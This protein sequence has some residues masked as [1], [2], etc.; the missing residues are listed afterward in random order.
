MKFYKNKD[1]IHSVLSEVIPQSTYDKAT[2]VYKKSF[3]LP[4]METVKEEV[5]DTDAEGNTIS[6]GFREVQKQVIKEEKVKIKNEEGKTVTQVV[7]TPQ[8]TTEVREVRYN[9]YDEQWVVIIPDD[10]KII[11]EDEYNKIIEETQ[12]SYVSSKTS[13]VQK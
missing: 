8:F 13:S 1:S 6:L 2:V 11:T 3:T 10:A 12:K 4:V 7:S 5:T 9:P